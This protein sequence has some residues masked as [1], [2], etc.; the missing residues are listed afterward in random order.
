MIGAPGG[1]VIALLLTPLLG[2]GTGLLIGLTVGISLGMAG[3]LADWAKVP[4]SDDRPQSPGDT[5]RRDAQLTYV[6]ILCGTLIL[7]PAGGLVGGLALR[8]TAAAAGLADAVILGL[9][10]GPVIGIAGRLKFATKGV[11]PPGAVR[12]PRVLGSR[13][14]LMP[15][16]LEASVIYAISVL[17]L[18]LRGRQPSGSCAS[19]RTRTGLGCCARSATSTSSGTRTFRTG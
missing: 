12:G 1:L 4:L 18:S 7:A 6:R 17:A 8:G 16:R 11:L 13:V 10:L 2:A 9:V 3:A 5:L 15:G 19:S 14:G